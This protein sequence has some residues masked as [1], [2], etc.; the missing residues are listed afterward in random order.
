M[1]CRIGLL[2]SL[3]PA[4]AAAE[5]V[6][7][8]RTL[9]AQTVIEAADVT[10]VDAEIDGALSAITPALGQELKTTVYAGRPLRPENLGAPALIERN[11]IV[12]LVYRSGGLVIL[13]DGRALARGAEGDVIRVMNLASKSTVSGRVG[14]DGHILV[15]DQN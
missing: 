11:Q 1:W 14:P 10:L 5:S 3:S 4:V 13:A 7:A 6:V 2:L 12:S 8:V 15:G 9:P